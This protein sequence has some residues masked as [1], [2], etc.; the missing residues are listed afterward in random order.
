MT[1]LRCDRRGAWQNSLA[2]S[3]FLYAAAAIDALTS[4]RSSPT[5]SIVAPVGRLDVSYHVLFYTLAAQTDQDYEV[6]R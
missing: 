4:V 5:V 2:A 1:L 6:I 3:V